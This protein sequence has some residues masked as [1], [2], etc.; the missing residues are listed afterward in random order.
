LIQFDQQGL[1][2][3]IPATPVFDILPPEKNVHNRIRWQDRLP[4][5]YVAYP[6]TPLP[7]TPLKG[8]YFQ[9]YWAHFIDYR[10]II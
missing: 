6:K 7:G 8:K 3:N 1:N 4:I 9:T 2:L 10:D 5:R